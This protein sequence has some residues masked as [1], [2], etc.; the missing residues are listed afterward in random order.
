MSEAAAM[1]RNAQTQRYD[2]IIVGGGSAGCVLANR[3]SAKSSNRVLLLEA[4]PDT[5]PG[6]EPEDVLSTYPFSYF[7]SAYK[8]PD[9]KVHWKTE[10][11]SSASRIPQG[12]ILGGG[13]SIM[14]MI[15]LRGTPDDYEE[16]KALGAKNWGW[17]EVLPFFRKLEADQDFDGPLHGKDGPVPIRRPALKDLPPVAQALQSYCQSR[18]IDLIEDLNAEYQNGFG[19][20]PISRFENKRGS[21]AICYLGREVRARANLEIVTAAQVQ[22]LI[23]ERAGE[24]VRVTGVKAVIKDKVVSFQGGEVIVSAG[25][26]QSPVFLLRAGVGPAEHLRQA[27]VEV[28]ADRP[29]VGANLHNH[30][31]LS[32]I[33]HLTPSGRTAKGARGHTTAMLRYSSDMEGCPASDMYIPYVANTGWHALGQRLSSFTPTIAKPLSRGRVSLKNTGSDLVP[34]IEFNYHS[35]ARDHARHKG[36]VLRAADMLLSAE[37]KPMWRT[38]VPLFRGDRAARFNTISS[39]NAVRA[40]AAATLLDLI[41]STSRPILGSMTKQ[42]IDVLKLLADDDALSEFVSASVS[43]PGHHVGTCR[44][45]PADDPD[46]VVDSA[47]RVYGVDGLRVIDASVMPWVPRG[48]TNIPT[49]MVAEKMAAEM[50]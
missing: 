31:L 19:I 24:R 17:E 16:W 30:H 36:A 23:K 15:A 29:G 18:Q 33:F 28:V 5:P 13:S 34:L 1:A 35:D 22:S 43:G 21:A 9:M 14:G 20:L 26:L 7:N 2:Y 4:G 46:A 10:A 41:P 12:R 32:L 38:A 39:A 40:R 8:W 48:N 3:L 37:L 27:G 47:G 50:E 44:I 11:T 25:A 49:L 6:E 45:G 42:G